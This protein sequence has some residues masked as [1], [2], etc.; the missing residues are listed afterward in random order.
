MPRM[1]TQ[2]LLALVCVLVITAAAGCRNDST[3]AAAAAHQQATPQSKADAR[4]QAAE[5]ELT[6]RIRKLG[7]ADGKQLMNEL[8]V[9]TPIGDDFA[10]TEQIGARQLEFRGKVLDLKDGRYRVSYD[11][12]ETSADGRQQL[13]SLIEMRANDEK[14]VG[15][16]QGAGGMETVVLSLSRP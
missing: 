14:E 2:P 16:V 4:P 8:V 10:V 5:I 3:A 6:V 13:K 7:G 12:A 9:A 1:R 15:G 11:Y